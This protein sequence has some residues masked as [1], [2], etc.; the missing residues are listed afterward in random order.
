MAEEKDRHRS[1][2]G[3]RLEHKLRVVERRDRFLH[4]DR[5]EERAVFEEVFDRSTLMTIYEL[6]NKGEIEDIYGVVKAG[7]ESRVYWGKTSNG[8]KVAVKIYLTASAEFRRGMLPYILGDPRFKGV[9]RD[10]RSLIYAWAQKEFKNLLSAREASVRVPKPVNV[11]NNVLLMEF[12]GE[13][14]VSAPLMKDVELKNPKQIFQKLLGY[15]IK[16]HKKAKLVHGDLSEYNVMMW[17]GEPVIF[18]L[19]QSVLTEH[20]NANQ[21]LLRDLENLYRY[22]KKMGVAVPSVEDLFRRVTGERI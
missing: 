21:L 20:P 11:K 7:K 22:F 16:L 4:K 9:K 18:D 10:S 2:E 12:I 6:M 19:S 5:S 17:K 14:G 1:V 3:K 8:E 13:N 15:V